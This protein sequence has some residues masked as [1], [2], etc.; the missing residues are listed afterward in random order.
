MIFASCGSFNSG[1]SG[2]HINERALRGPGTA[3]VLPFLLLLLL[4]FSRFCCCC[5]SYCAIGLLLLS[6]WIARYSDNKD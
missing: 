2:E 1:D 6:C 4:L 3:A 5:F